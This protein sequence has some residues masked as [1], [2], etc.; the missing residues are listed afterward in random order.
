MEALHVFPEPVG[1]D[2]CE[3]ALVAGEGQLQVDD[4]HVLLQTLLEGAPVA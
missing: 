1:G 3:L 2:A 4:P